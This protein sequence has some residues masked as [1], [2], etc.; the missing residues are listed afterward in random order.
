LLWKE[1]TQSINDKPVVSEEN[2]VSLI[3]ESHSTTT[4]ELWFIMKES[5]QHPRYRITQVCTK[6][7][8]NDFR[9]MLRDFLVTPLVNI[10]T[11]LVTSALQLTICTVVQYGCVPTHTFKTEIFV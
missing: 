4:P 9:T 11:I 6:I 8:Q 10:K 5:R 2:I 3:V 7:V 1:S